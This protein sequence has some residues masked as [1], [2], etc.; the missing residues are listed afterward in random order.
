MNNA[1][2]KCLYLIWIYD[3]GPENNMDIPVNTSHNLNVHK[4]FL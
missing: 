4:T 1:S 2:K 3:N